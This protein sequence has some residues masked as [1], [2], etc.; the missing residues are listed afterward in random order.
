[1]GEDAIN[2]LSV[3]PCS[4]LDEESQ[5]NA[6]STGQDGVEP[7]LPGNGVH[8]EEVPHNSEHDDKLHMAQRKLENLIL[9]RLYRSSSCPD[10]GRQVAVRICHMSCQA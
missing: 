2:A 5:R 6:T 7:A 10:A 9:Q 3:A 1:M 4:K 8:F